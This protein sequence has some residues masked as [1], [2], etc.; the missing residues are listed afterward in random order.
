M[1]MLYIYTKHTV[2]KGGAYSETLHCN[3]SGGGGREA[4]TKNEGK[5]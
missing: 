3:Q 1:A 2:L 4:P 5:F